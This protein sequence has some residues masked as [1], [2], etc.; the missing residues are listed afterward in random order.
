[1]RCAA[2]LC[3]PVVPNLGIVQLVGQDIAIV[4]AEVVAGTEDEVEVYFYIFHYSIDILRLGDGRRSS[5]RT[6]DG[7]VFRTQ[8][9][10]AGGIFR[11]A[12]LTVFLDIVRVF[13]EEGFFCRCQQ[14]PVPIADRCV[15]T[16]F[17]L[18]NLYLSV[19][20]QLILYVASIDGIVSILVR[21]DVE[22]LHRSVR[23]GRNG[24]RN[25]HL[26][27]VGVGGSGVGR[28]ELVVDVDGTLDVPVVG[29]HGTTGLFDSLILGTD[30]IAVVNDGLRAVYEV[31]RCLPLV[32][33][34][35]IS[36]IRKLLI[37]DGTIV[38]FGNGV[39]IHA[40]TA[41]YSVDILGIDETTADARL[42]IDQVQLDDTSDIAPL[43]FV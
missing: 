25:L 15:K 6:P 18:V 16:V 17:Y 26:L 21:H 38:Q 43:L 33:M 35:I 1:M 31:T 28:D 11:I 37:A 42:H 34:T 10:G 24:Q 3:V 13:D 29:R 9:H 22:Q 14:I 39:V 40:R 32:L 30:V 41:T 12:N 36:S 4:V 20:G 2:D 5:A 19:R 27:A 8:Q 23:G 7:F